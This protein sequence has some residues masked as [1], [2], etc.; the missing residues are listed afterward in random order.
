MAN[1]NNLKAAIDAVIKTNGR[2]EI[3][4]AALNTQL[5][6]M[7][8]E[9]GAG[10]QYMGIATPATN[11]GTPDANVFYL[12]SE[13][14]TY[15][16][17]GGIVINEGEVCV[18]VWNGTW[19]K[20]VTGA[21]TADQVSRL[22]QLLN[23]GYQ[24]R[25]VAVLTP[26]QTN[27][28]NVDQNIFFLAHE[29]GTYTNFGDLVVEDGELAALIYTKSSNLWVKKTIA[30][31]PDD[32]NELFNRQIA[33]VIPQSHNWSPYG[34]G[35]S[36]S[37]DSSTQE[38]TYG[39]TA[40]NNSG[41]TFAAS[42]NAKP[43][44]IRMR[45]YST[46]NGQKMV[47]G[48]FASA[49]SEDKKVIELSTTPQEYF[50]HFTGKN[51]IDNDYSP[52]F[53]VFGAD[54]NIG[55]EIHITLFN[56]SEDGDIATRVAE[57]TEKIAENTEKIAEIVESSDYP[58]TNNIDSVFQGINKKNKYLTKICL[59]GDSLL[60][61]D[62]GGDIPSEVDEGNTKRPMRLLTNNVARR[63]YDWMSWNKPIWRR[64][65][66]ADWT[67][68]GFASFSP[69]DFFYGTQE[70]YCRATT[71]GAYMEITIPQGYE[72][73]ALI[74][75][76]KTGMGVLN[77]TINGNLPST[78]KYTN[79]VLVGNPQKTQ[80][81]LETLIENN[82]VVNSSVVPLQLPCGNDTINLAAD[83]GNV[84][85]PYEIY[86]FHNL[87]SG[88]ANV[89]RF[90]TASAT[91]CD[92]WGGFYWSGNTMVIMDIAR[93]GHTSTQLLQYAP[94]QLYNVQYDALMWEFP[95]MN[96]LRL[97][98][99]QSEANF[100]SMISSLRV[101]GIDFVF[102]SCN[103]LGLSIVHDTNFYAE[104][105]SPTQEDINDKIRSVAN[106]LRVPFIDLFKYF[107]WN[108]VNKG[109]N[110]A[111]GEG[112]LW[113][114]WDG[115]HGNPDGVRLWFEALKKVFEKSPITISD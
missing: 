72:H 53:G 30:H 54:K 17:F 18:L 108:I 114:T 112:G 79:P 6:N 62:I 42:T 4:G 109:G 5:K 95:E 64:F 101:K 40:A 44:A 10:Y 60:A 23:E 89:I 32:Y 85:N 14:G 98:L 31:I 76:K 90:T 49:D 38:V 16:N 52:G 73:F 87:P 56:V 39:L 55:A 47:V 33:G 24:F 1:Y 105:T 2:Q 22:G 3:S 48:L 46:V 81:E 57:N 7:I 80:Q 106:E 70:Q 93:G 67:K 78:I 13:A 100:R 111:G 61:N 51:S 20:Q 102:T 36:L 27:P 74:A 34:S 75:N 99:A 77:V 63:L 103:P 21:A 15:T 66:N 19:T 25:N 68:S 84:G 88:Q 115:Q 28:G 107:E 91:E 11:P 50:L 43:Y 113:F 9:L 26:A 41:V 83:A 110:L 86:E 92:V 8:A 71:S 12:A 45:A 104:Y 29:A 96:D 35:Y 59:F 65:D 97:T 82:S 69:V 94:D 58:F 37:V